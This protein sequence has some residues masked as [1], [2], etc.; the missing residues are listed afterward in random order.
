MS[1]SSN[2]D[3]FRDGGRWPY[4]SCFVGCCLNDL[5]NIARSILVQLPSSFFSRRLFS[6]LLV[7]PYS[8]IDTIVVWKELHF[9][10]S[11]MSD[12]HMTDSLL[13][14]VHVFLSRVSMSA[15]V[16]ER[17]LPRLQQIQFS[18]ST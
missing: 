11:I 18:M 16:G 7:H 4:S 8:S 2:F 15:S 14:A 1:G 13:I 12:F 17:L 3:S 9:L 5:F 6:V 10:L